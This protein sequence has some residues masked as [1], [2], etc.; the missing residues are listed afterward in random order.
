MKASPSSEPPFDLNGIYG[1]MAKRSG[2]FIIELVM[3]EIE[4]AQE[5]VLETIYV[6]YEELTN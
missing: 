2:P 3:V 4:I 5:S 1:V 6:C